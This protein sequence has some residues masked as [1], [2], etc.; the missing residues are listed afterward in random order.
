MNFSTTY[1]PHT[2][3]QIDGINL[4]IDDMLRIYVMDKPS[5]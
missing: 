2:D 4:V 1:H 3:G 5:K